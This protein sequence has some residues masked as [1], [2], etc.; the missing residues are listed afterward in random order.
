MLFIC[1][2]IN[3]IIGNSDTDTEQV[4]DNKRWLGNKVKESW[5]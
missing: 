5:H 3:D 1:D 4:N 2:L